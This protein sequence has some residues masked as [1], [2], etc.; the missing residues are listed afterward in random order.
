M[1]NVTVLTPTYNRISDL[2]KLYE[3]LLAQTVKDFIW[4]IVDDGSSDNTESA[5][6]GWIDG[7][8]LDIIY[9]KQ[10]NGGKHRALNNGIAKIRT[11]LTFIVDSDDRLTPDAISVVE[12]KYNQH[13]N[14]GDIC[15]ISFLRGTSDG[16]LLSSGK[17]PVDGMKESFVQCRINRNIAGDMAE[18]WLTRCLREYPFPTFKNEKFLGEDVVWIKMSEK[19]K[20]IFYN[21]VIYLSD[22]LDDGLTKNRRQHNIRSPRGCVERARVFLEADINM[23]VKIKAGLQY[24]IYGNFAGTPYKQQYRNCPDRLLFTALF[25]P[26]E[27]LYR[28][29]KMELNT[30]IRKENDFTGKVGKKFEDHNK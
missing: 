3:S 4:M 14:E 13:K 30:E 28:K 6:K 2:N 7:G 17:V 12:E 25:V 23:K 26:A 20:L 9:I 27:I 19:Y 11:P 29:W 5:V 1:G 21:N 8:R 22:Y 24:I 16:G 10:K 15:G 18:V